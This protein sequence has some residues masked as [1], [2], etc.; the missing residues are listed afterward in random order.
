MSIFIFVEI[1]TGALRG[2]GDV[3]IPTLITLGGV[4]LVRLPWIIFVTPIRRELFTILVSYPIAWA[5]TALLLIPYY[6][7]RKKKLNAKW[8]R[9]YT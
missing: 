5:A 9:T 6:F 1:F 4:C 8:K 3:M 2:I 7:Y